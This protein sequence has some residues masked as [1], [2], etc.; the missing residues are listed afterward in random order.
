[1]NQNKLLRAIT[2]LLAA[3]LAAAQ[4][5]A[6]TVETQNG[7]RLGGQVTKIDGGSVTLVTD[8]AGTITLKQAEVVAINTDAP[9]AVRL[10]SGTRID[11]KV[12]GSGGNVQV[13]SSDG[14]VNTTVDKIAASWG[15]GGKD[16]QLVA[17]ERGWAYEATVDVSGKSGNKSQLGTAAGLRATLAGVSDTL[18]F[19]TNYDL[20]SPGDRWPEIRRPVQGGGRLHQQFLR[21]ELLVC[22]QRRWLRSHQGHP[23]LRRGRLRPRL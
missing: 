5:S 20:R 21:Q 11:G 4:L 1:M 3:V 22:A 6:D 16:P 17:L 19:Y 10:A 23:V 18:V 7:S 15:A 14:A 2:G 13:A 12:S 8:Y 9:V